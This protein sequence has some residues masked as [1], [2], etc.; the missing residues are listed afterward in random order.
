[1][2]RSA[3]AFMKLYFTVQVLVDKASADCPNSHEDL[4]PGAAWEMMSASSILARSVGRRAFLGSAALSAAVPVLMGVAAAMPSGAEHPG[5]L[6][7]ELPV[8]LREPPPPGAILINANENPLG[9][10]SAACKA[11]ADMASQGARYDRFGETRALI[12]TFA[13]QHALTT[14]CVAAYDGS[15]LPL[16]YTLLAFTSP[17][18]G[19]VMADPCYEAPL[20]GA[21]MSGARV[22]KVPLTENLAHDVKAMVA[23]DPSAGVFYVC[24]PNNPTGTLTSREA[25]AWLLEHKPPGSV[26]LVDEAYIQFSDA[27]SVLDMV[28]AGKD[29][30]VLRT[31]SKIYG[32]AGIRCG[33]AAARPDLL[34]RLVK[35]GLNAMPITASAAARVSLLDEALVPTRRK[36]VGDTRRETISWL[37]ASGYRVIGESQT[38]HFLLDT[39]RDG[40]AVAAAMKAHNVYIGPSWDIWPTAVR[41]SVGTPEEMATFRTVFQTVM[42]APASG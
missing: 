16:H 31:F 24:N 7:H 12:K 18:R 11:I 36:I 8:W 21:L 2:A 40:R 3:A 30:I 23:A 39:R 13:D 6:D 41:V 14:A 5:A 1:M 25:I 28:A 4:D 32:M 26:V 20:F 37:K 22:S 9:P 33:F 38:N 17:S 34:A 29:L 10:S 19:L 42:D 27:P 35:F 15:S